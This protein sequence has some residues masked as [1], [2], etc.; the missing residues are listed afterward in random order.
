[1]QLR[2]HVSAGPRTAE[3]RNYGDGTLTTRSVHDGH[4]QVRACRGSPLCVCLLAATTPLVA[5]RRSP[6]LRATHTQRGRRGGRLVDRTVG[7][8]GVLP[9]APDVHAGRCARCDTHDTSRRA[10]MAAAV[11]AAAARERRARGGGGAG[12]GGDGGCGRR[13]SRMRPAA[14]VRRAWV[15]LAAAVE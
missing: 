15:V 2:A 6:G 5:L 9:R 1:M 11:A 8:A 12:G 13:W 3:A 4:A 14:R 7:R 10:A